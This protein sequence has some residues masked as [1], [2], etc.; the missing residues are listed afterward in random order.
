MIRIVDKESNYLVLS[1]DNVELLFSYDTCVAGYTPDYGNFKT[2]KFH[3]K[4][5]SKH[6]N[7]YL[8]NKAWETIENDKINEIIKNVTVI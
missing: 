2:D 5:T 8:R 7:K 6:V 3:S 4:T 1:V